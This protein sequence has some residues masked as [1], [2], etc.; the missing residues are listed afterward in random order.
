M[1]PAMQDDRRRR[2]KD[3]GAGGGPR[4]IR[5]RSAG[6]VAVHDA[7]DGT[8]R[9]LLVHSI[10]VQNPAARWE[11]PKGHIEGGLDEQQ[12]ALKE[13]GEEAGVT[14]VD[15]LPGFR[16]EV[17]WTYRDG[18]GRLVDKSAVYFVGRV[19]DRQLPPSPPTPEE[20]GPG[21]E[22][23]WARWLTL[24]QATQLLAHAALRNLLRNADTFLGAPVGAPARAAAEPPKAAG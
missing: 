12:T 4:R 6:V 20:I 21:P 16:E 7:P 22:G 13:L 2:G 23:D 5:V 3:R 15:L 1:L 11:V 19:P 24:E 8:R 17:F 14:K 9:F 10:L 18:Q